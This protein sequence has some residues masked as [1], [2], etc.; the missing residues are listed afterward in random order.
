[1]PAEVIRIFS[2]LHYGD[3]SSRVDRLQGLT[4]LAEGATSWVINGDLLDT[5]AGPRPDL[6][7]ECRE[8]AAAY[9]RDLGLPATLLTGNHD[10]D[11]S[12]VHFLSLAQGRVFL[13]HGDALYDTIVPWGQDAPYVRRRMAEERARRGSAARPTLAEELAIFRI[14]AA[15]I[16]Q[17][18]QSERNRLRYLRRLAADTIWPPWRVPS[19]FAAWLSYAGRARGFSARHA[20]GAQ[21]VLNG[22]THRAGIWRKPGAPTI[23]NTGALCRPFQAWAIDLAEE[24]L[25]IREIEPRQGEFR[26]GRR[27]AELPLATP[28]R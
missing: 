21:F 1:M 27:V 25:L 11:I 14:I 17:R 8:Q 26:L 16:P 3:K 15:E 4:P 23:L 24:R 13:T 9:L 12:D 10:P 20:P 22:H 28:G 19:I 7:R 2:D 6:T 18:H 5:R